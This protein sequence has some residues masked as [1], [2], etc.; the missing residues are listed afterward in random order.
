M[1]TQSKPVIMI[2]G[3]NTH[4]LVAVLEEL[5]FDQVTFVVTDTFSG[6]EEYTMSV[7]NDEAKK[8]ASVIEQL[9]IKQVFLPSVVVLHNTEKEEVSA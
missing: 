1:I 5:F 4:Q 6:M 3:H 8:V 2:I 7:K 9:L